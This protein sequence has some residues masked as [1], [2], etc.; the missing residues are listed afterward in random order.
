MRTNQ[1]SK[2][3]AA[4]VLCG[5]LW[6]GAV[7]AGGAK[8]GADCPSPTPGLSLCGKVETALSTCVQE[9]T[10]EK[11]A[12]KKKRGKGGLGFLSRLFI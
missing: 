5:G 4:V 3:I 8:A 10:C 7:L 6:S 12:G 2:V 11:K 9:R 1:F